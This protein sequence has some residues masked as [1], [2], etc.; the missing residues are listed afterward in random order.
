MYNV[1]IF[2]LLLFLYI[3]QTVDGPHWLLLEVK[4]DIL[5]ICIKTKFKVDLYSSNYI[6]ICW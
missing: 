3:N 1:L 5:K 6:V 4:E 2:L